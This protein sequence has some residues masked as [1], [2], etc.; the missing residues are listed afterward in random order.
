M[1]THKR[2]GFTLLETLL[3]L[4]IMVS[5]FAL[6]WPAIRGPLAKAR[7]KR[8]A[9]DVQTSLG[10]ARARAVEHGAAYAF[11]YQIDGNEFQILAWDA[12]AAEESIEADVVAQGPLI[13]SFE[14]ETD[15]T[16]GWNEEGA[17]SMTALLRR[18][19]S[20]PMTSRALP[21]GVRFVEEPADD[22][23]LGDSADG[24]SFAAD[25][26]VGGEAAEGTDRG[27]ITD[28]GFLEES[29]VR[30][31]RPI[32]FW[33]N[34]RSQNARVLLRDVRNYSI[35][36]E[37]RGLTGIARYGAAV[38]PAI[39]DE[40]GDGEFAQ[41]QFSEGGNELPGAPRGATP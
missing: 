27:G 23:L 10:K 15:T 31:S 3:V 39:L 14:A 37:L 8:A 13:D 36:V 7:L 6:S 4:A 35:S 34:G 19:R 26:V 33:P 41:Q 21:E 1:T 29:S 25:A 30:W 11:R 40:E 12:L 28:E 9:R 5:L 22:L 2:S 32:V 24:S 16:G 20:L 18:P 17:S 38:R